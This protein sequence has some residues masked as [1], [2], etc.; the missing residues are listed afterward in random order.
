M[1]AAG[2]RNGSALAFSGMGAAMLDDSN[3]DHQ[4]NG[5]D[6]EDGFEPIMDVEALELAL[7]RTNDGMK[8]LKAIA[9]WTAA[10]KSDGWWIDDIKAAATDVGKRRGIS[11]KDISA[12][13]DRGQDVWLDANTKNSDIWSDPSMR[14]ARKT[15]DQRL[16]RPIVSD[17]PRKPLPL[18]ADTAELLRASEVKMKAVVW[19]W[20]NRFA[21]GKQSIVGGDP[22][23]GKSTLLAYIAARISRGDLWPDGT[24]AP[25]GNVIIL[26]AEDTLEDTVVPRLVAAD[27]D[28]GRIYFYKMTKLKN[29]RKRMFSLLTDL[30]LLESKIREVGNVIAV[31]FDPMSAYFGNGRLDSHNNTELR[32]VLGPISDLAERHNVA[33]ISNGHLNKTGDTRALMRF[34]G[35]LA[36]VAQARCAYLA[37]EEMTDGKLTGR[38]LFLEAKNNL[39]PKQGGLAYRI[40]PATVGEGIVTSYVHWDAGPVTITANQALAATTGGSQSRHPAQDDAQVFLRE[41]LAYGPVWVQEL[42]KEAKDA[43]ISW[44]SIRRVKDKLVE[45][46]RDKETKRYFWNLKND[47]VAQVAHHKRAEQPEQPDDE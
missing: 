5:H 47:E 22:G 30:E 2:I 28:L 11:R 42:Q 40:V 19:L 20:L 32:S 38:V 9:E 14:E 6:P 25:L 34:M 35:S 23:L 26:T 44:A 17:P 4:A 45:I 41:L 3:Y 43:G 21:L 13:V 18:L 46:T 1:R 12:A 24:R 33:V 36:F 27:A 29:G 8:R 31:I 10:Q 37:V 16:A 7:D 15:L 39:G